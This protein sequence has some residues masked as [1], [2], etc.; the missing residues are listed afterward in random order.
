MVPVVD[1]RHVFVGVVEQQRCLA[2]LESRER[3][4]LS[5][6]LLAHL[7]DM[8]VVDVT[9][10]AGPDEL[11]DVEADLLGDHMRQQRVA[12]DV[13]RDAEEQVGAALVELARQPTVRDV[14]LEQRV[15]RRKCHLR[16]LRD[17]PRRH[18]HA[19]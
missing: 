16:N 17:V 8:V 18:D 3:V 5:R 13:E 2:K 10:A 14:E 4:D 15:A 6:K 1:N 7:L 12:G 11:T 19:P 9:V